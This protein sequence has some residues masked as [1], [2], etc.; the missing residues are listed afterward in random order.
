M[1]FAAAYA[2][3]YLGKHPYLWT[4]AAVGCA[5]VVRELV[6]LVLKNT[7]GDSLSM[8]LLKVVGASLSFLV[9]CMAG[10]WFGRRHHDEFFAK[11][12]ARME[13][14][15]S[16]PAAAAQQQ[17]ATLNQTRPTNLP[18]PTARDRRLE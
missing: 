6:V 8:W 12:L 17:A 15:A 14:K 5:F 10:V 9:V 1:F 11:K 4:T 2:S 7:L 3:H 18:A 16:P 13:R